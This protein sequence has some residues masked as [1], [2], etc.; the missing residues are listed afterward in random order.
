MA[1]SAMNALRKA[2]KLREEGRLG[3]AERVCKTVLASDPRDY[4]AL[5]LS[6]VLMHQQGRS[7]EALRM[8]AAALKEK[9]GAADILANYGV[10]LEALGRYEEALAIFDQVLAKGGGDANLHCKRGNALQ[11][12][13]R[14]DEALESYDRALVLAP[15]LGFVHYNRG[16]TL[17]RMNRTKEALASFDRAI[18]LAPPD[19]AVG[20]GGRSPEA[21][22]RALVADPYSIAA[23][24]N[25]GTLLIEL[26][27]YEE[28]VVALNEAIA[29][30]PNYA[31]AYGNRGVALAE[32]GRY[33]EAFADYD[34]ALRLT[35]HLADP[36]ANRGNAFLAL[37][38]M[39]EALLGYEAALAIDPEH[40]DANF[41]TGVTRLC[42][43]DFGRA[44]KHYEYRWYRKK[45][46]VPKPD[47]PQPLWRGEDVQGKTVLLCGEQGMGD[48]IQFVRYAPM[49]AARGA[50][51]FL[52]VHPA[53]TALL[54][55]VDGV[56]EVIAETAPLP[57]FDFYCPLMCLPQAFDT[58]LE[59]IPAGVPYIRAY[60]SLADKWRERLPDRGRLRVGICWAGSGA[61]ANN[62]R[63]SMTLEYFADILAVPNVDF[64]SVQKDVAA[65]DEPILDRYGVVK[66][67]QDFADFAD[68]AA[69]MTMLDL[70]ISVDT[71][72]AHL[73]GAL[74]K[75]TAVLIPF[76][77][78][79][80]WM[81]DRADTPWYPTMR[82]FRQPA[83]DDWTSPIDQLRRE[84]AGVAAR[85]TGAPG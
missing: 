74:G 31:D 82:L 50:K 16:N 21:I 29:R 15:H 25:R 22:R 30:A 69:V 19:M 12:L 83:I 62:R 44:W 14:F 37:N 26:K 66:I 8:V 75:A 43:G 9:P 5:H 6:G 41:N 13:G 1:S 63:R 42:L 76:S 36:H 32:L 57:D 78:D 7:A 24:N 80:R 45:N 59:T 35:P 10:I 39:D 33:D 27:R 58:R 72:V 54:A 3:A 46:P 51:V 23:R 11:Q 52:R 47:F 73:A 71:S 81:L 2:V 56:A 40:A 55:T 68:T 4:N 17:A 67:G 77:P 61:H 84:L 20:S 70:I 64:I 18:A 34:T 79:W 48:V 60:T 65:A 28:A 85:R 53:L 49:V 38:R